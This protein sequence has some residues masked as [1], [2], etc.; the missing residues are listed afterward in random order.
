MKR[1]VVLLPV[2][3][4]LGLVSAAAA[5]AKCSPQVQM[6]GL[7]PNE[8]VIQI[9]GSVVLSGPGNPV[10]LD[11]LDPSDI[12]SIEITCWN[13]ATGEFGGGGRIPVIVIATKSFVESRRAPLDRLLRAQEAHF[14]QFSRYARRLV[15]LVA[16]GVPHDS[17]LEFS[18]TSA[19]WS[20]ATPQVD[21]AYRCF[22]SSGDAAEGLTRVTQPEVVCRDGASPALREMYEASA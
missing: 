19:G 5:A 22:V 8:A 10:T 20:A 2:F 14:S 15:D 3:V 7:G 13:P 6:P 1:R 18:A 9:D 16:F 4:A 11:E 12:H 17:M 21:A